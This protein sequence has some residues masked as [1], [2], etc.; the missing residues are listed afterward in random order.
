MVRKAHPFSPQILLDHPRLALPP[1]GDL[2]AHPTQRRTGQHP[3][4]RRVA[5]GQHPVVLTA[6]QVVGD[7]LQLAGL[8][9]QGQDVRL[10]VPRAHVTSAGQGPRLAGL[11]VGTQNFLP[12]RTA[13]LRA[14]RALLTAL[15]ERK[16]A[17]TAREIL[18]R[19]A[20]SIKG[21]ASKTKDEHHATLFNMWAA[22]IARA[23]R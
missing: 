13:T 22:E 6:H 3:L 4:P 5:F 16:D 7:V 11:C 2:E 17:E 8:E 1:G 23:L 19:T 12:A 9:Q 15:N 20:A 10:P 21:I 14:K 18:E